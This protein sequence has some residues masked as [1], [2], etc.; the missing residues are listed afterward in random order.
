MKTYG[1][2]LATALLVVGTIL[3]AACPQRTTIARIDR[4]PG[5]F[6]GKEVTIAGHVRNSYGAMGTGVFE[7]EDETGHMWV[8]SERYGIPGRDARLAV[9]G[10]IE[11]GFSFGGRNFAVVLRET[12]RRH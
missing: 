9:T 1:K 6:A 12:E 3:L 2:Y 11:Q 4:D 7:L 8:F 10:R 5:R